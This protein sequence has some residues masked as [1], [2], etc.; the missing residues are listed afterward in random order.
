MSRVYNFAAGP[1]T[2]PLSVLE[3][4]R[5][6]LLDWQQKGMSLMEISHRSPEFQSLVADTELDLRELLNIPSNYKV[7]F[8]PGGAQIQFS[9]IPMNLLRGKQTAEY[10]VTG[11]WSLRTI[12]EAKNHCDPHI[13][14]SNES[15]GF[16]EVPDIS[17]WKRA[18]NA[19]YLHYTS[20]ETIDGVQID[21]PDVTD[22]PLVADM[23]SDLLSKPID[24]SKFG[25]IYACTQKNIGPAGMTIVIVRDDLIDKPSPQT[26]RIFNYQTQAQENSLANTPPTFS[27]YLT[28]LV[29]KWIKEQGGLKVMAEINS[30]KAQKLYEAIDKNDFYTNNINPNCRSQMNVRFSL[31]TPELEAKFIQEAAHNGLA[32]L[33]GHKLAGGIRASLYNAVPESA[34]DSLIDFMGSRLE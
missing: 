27:W 8:L 33:K 6:E 18:K 10:L 28:G 3:Q 26:P 11:R 23:S 22:V 13:V 34:V 32:N 29:L 2:I 30:R 4:A 14:A 7:L 24:V 5:D 15:N 21:I 9:M 1:A 16:T 20:N 17:T 19:A 25:L 31:P 12:N